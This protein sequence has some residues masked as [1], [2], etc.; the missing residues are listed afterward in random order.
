VRIIEELYGGVFVSA[1]SKGLY[2]EDTEFTEIAQESGH[3][4]PAAARDL[5]I[6]CPYNGCR[7]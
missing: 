5:A 6:S 4:V 3:D 2:T 7:A 1:D